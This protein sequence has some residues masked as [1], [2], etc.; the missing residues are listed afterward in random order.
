L[1]SITLFWVYDS[2][3]SNGRSSD[4]TEPS[5]R[6][7]K[8]GS[9]EHVVIDQTR[10]NYVSFAKIK[11]LFSQ[12]K[13]LFQKKLPHF[14]GI[15]FKWCLFRKKPIAVVPTSLGNTKGSVEEGPPP[16]KSPSAT[17]NQH[18]KVPE[19]VGD[20][21]REP[22]DPFASPRTPPLLDP[23]VEASIQADLPPA[24]SQQEAQ[25]IK[26]AD[27]KEES[28]SL[29]PNGTENLNRETQNPDESASSRTDSSNGYTRGMFS[30]V[31]ST[32]YNATSAVCSFVSH[33]F[34]CM[35]SLAPGV[36]SAA[37]GVLSV[38]YTAAQ[39]MVLDFNPSYFSEDKDD[40][41]DKPKRSDPHVVE[42]PAEI[43]PPPP[44]KPVIPA[45]VTSLEPSS[46]TQS[47]LTPADSLDVTRSISESP[48]L[49]EID[50]ASTAVSLVPS[51]PSLNLKVE[52][53]ECSQDNE[54]NI[55]YLINAFPNWF[56]PILLSKI[57]TLIAKFSAVK[58]VHP[59]KFLFVVFS[60]P[61]IKCNMLNMFKKHPKYTSSFFNGF[62][63][64]NFSDI[65]LNARFTTSKN[66]NE[67]LPYLED[68][69]RITHKD[70]PTLR[71]FVEAEKWVEMFH[72]VLDYN[73]T[74]KK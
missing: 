42:D 66:T 21:K 60:N 71:Q 51:A 53:L 61:S 33:P 26:T 56:K 27:P 58:D 28:S 63:Y 35:S 48:P 15:K 10:S 45:S 14:R 52:N 72:Y 7:C 54:A 30:Y 68:F 43:I 2:F 11:N 22:Q 19:T 41:S 16:L 39:A 38:A 59:L 32:A 9:S 36:M 70:L 46:T 8:L 37:S 25:P 55:G 67:L 18:P 49:S 50:S 64:L 6:S 4:Q 40:K 44:S 24:T 23:P 73:P 65:G 74:Q 31:G 62:S 12:I 5:P 3:P 57:F 20:L 69:A 13:A 47:E 29:N 17:S 34:R 1:R